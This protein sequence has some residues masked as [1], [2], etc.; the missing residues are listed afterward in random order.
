MALLRQKAYE[1]TM[2][3]RFLT[4]AIAGQR[5]HFEDL[6]KAAETAEAIEQIEVSYQ[7]NRE[8]NE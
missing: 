5:Q 2:Q 7:L 8:E 3:F 1:K 4:N 6:L